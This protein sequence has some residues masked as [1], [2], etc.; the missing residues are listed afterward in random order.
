MKTGISNLD[1]DYFIGL[2]DLR[3]TNW[4]DGHIDVHP[5]SDWHD[6]HGKLKQHDGQPGTAWR[7]WELSC[8]SCRY[9]MA[10]HG[11]RLDGHDRRLMKPS[12]IDGGIGLDGLRR[13][14]IWW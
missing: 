14:M 2:R 12:W 5:D 6:G 13:Q 9:R 1:S 3:A 7:N 10:Q 8:R 11:A 4:H